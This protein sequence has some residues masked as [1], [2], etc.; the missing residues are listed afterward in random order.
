M[1]EFLEKLV[2]PVVGDVGVQVIRYL[3]D[4]A[5]PGTRELGFANF[6]SIASE[7]GVKGPGRAEQVRRAFDTLSAMRIVLNGRGGFDTWL[8][9][10]SKSPGLVR[11]SVGDALTWDGL[12]QLDNVHPDYH[13]RVEVQVHRTVVVT[14]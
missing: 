2:A 1:S 11:V 13:G 8:L 9:A 7:L 6:E 3:V 14:G 4:M 5:V 12:K 10:Y